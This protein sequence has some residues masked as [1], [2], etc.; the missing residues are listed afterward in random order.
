MPTPTHLSKE[1]CHCPKC[2]AD[3]AILELSLKDF[4]A[5]IYCTTPA[6]GYTFEPKG[7][8]SAKAQA[9]FKEGVSKLFKE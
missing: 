3:T 9:I 4:T 5:R 7:E 8:D 6:C 2:N 1:P